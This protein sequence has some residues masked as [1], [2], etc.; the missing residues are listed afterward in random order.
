MQR[1]RVKFRRGEELKF[2]SHLDITRLWQRAFTRAGIP[3]AYSQGFNPHPQISL[4]AP[5]A[6]GT[7]GEAELMDIYCAKNVSPPF[8]TQAVNRELPV[9]I[10]IM[11][12]QQVNPDLPSLQSSI[13]LAD[14]EVTVITEKTQEEIAQ[15]ISRL[16]ALKE[17]PW[18]H[19]RDTG[20]RH[21]DLRRLI[22]DLRL[23]H[24]G[25][26]S[27]V[28][29]MKLACAATGSGRPEQVILALGFSGYPR[30]I[31]RTQLFLRTV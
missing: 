9:G 29:G 20:I 13:S 5:L 1:M 17:L 3:L 12:A 24:Y 10:M 15:A 6:V 28:I 26:G 30:A 18:Q 14:Y 4:A 27:A 31:N 25:E 23:V 19:E 21:Y 8:F 16:L 2:I 7:T 22:D 11:Q